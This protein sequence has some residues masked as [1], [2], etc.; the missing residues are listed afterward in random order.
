MKVE[1]KLRLKPLG[2]QVVVIAGAPAA[3]NDDALGRLS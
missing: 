1:T 2:E 3:R